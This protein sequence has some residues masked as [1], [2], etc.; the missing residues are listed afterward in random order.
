MPDNQGADEMTEANRI[1]WAVDAHHGDDCTG[2]GWE[3]QGT[4]MRVYYGPAQ[5]RQPRHLQETS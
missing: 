2:C 4:S 5:T 1:R 3:Y